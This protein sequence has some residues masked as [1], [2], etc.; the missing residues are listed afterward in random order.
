[1]KLTKK[2]VLTGSISAGVLGLSTSA[3][4]ALPAGFSDGLTEMQT[5]AIGMIDAIWP[6]LLAIAGAFLAIKIF[7]RVT[8]KL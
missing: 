4:A 1:M 3:F 2:S 8:S 6:F 5:D 7:K